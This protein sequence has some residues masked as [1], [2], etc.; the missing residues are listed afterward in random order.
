MNDAAKTTVVL[1]I[2]IIGFLLAAGQG[3]LRF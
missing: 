3:M 2:V 1:A